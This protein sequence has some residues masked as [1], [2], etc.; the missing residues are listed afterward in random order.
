MSTANVETT[1]VYLPV[2]PIPVPNTL[3]PEPYNFLA[4]IVT[5]FFLLWLFRV[6]KL[7][8][9]T[10]EM[11]F[12]IRS[13]QV[14]FTSASLSPSISPFLLSLLS[15]SFFFLVVVVIF[16]WMHFCSLFACVCFHSISQIGFSNRWFGI[17]YRSHPELD[18]D[19]FWSIV[20]FETTLSTS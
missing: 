18:K 19:S 17:P 5:C 7:T 15:L 12:A 8:V 16:L 6:C 4:I 10:N 2:V 11:A 3:S 1:T 14:Y 20:A 9:S 13:G